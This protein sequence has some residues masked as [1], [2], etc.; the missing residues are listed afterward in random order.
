MSAHVMSGTS[1]TLPFNFLLMYTDLAKQCHLQLLVS[2]HI[3][4]YHRYLSLKSML[5]LTPSF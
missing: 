4:F 3:F 1:F 5:S 2:L